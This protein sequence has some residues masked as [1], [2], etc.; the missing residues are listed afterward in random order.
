MKQLQLT[1]NELLEIGFKKRVS[2]ANKMN[3]SKA[4][5]KIPTVNGCFYFNP[6]KKVYVWYHKTVIGNTSNYIHLD[7]T[8]KPELFTLLSCF[9]VKF[10]LSL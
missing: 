5:F 1:E 3:P 8:S 10:N 9:K 4:F 6:N 2:K 7:I